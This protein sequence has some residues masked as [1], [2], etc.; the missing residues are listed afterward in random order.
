MVN[1]R[2]L[3]PQIQQIKHNLFTTL[4]DDKYRKNTLFLKQLSVSYYEKE[5]F[6]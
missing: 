5:V 4:S 1:N 6:I 3:S 2:S